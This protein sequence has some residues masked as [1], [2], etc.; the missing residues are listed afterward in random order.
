MTS[1]EMQNC[2]IRNKWMLCRVQRGN[3]YIICVFVARADSFINRR[4]VKPVLG[5]L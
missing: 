3:Y 2:H 4:Y 5:M 1:R